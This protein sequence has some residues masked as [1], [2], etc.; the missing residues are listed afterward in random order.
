M[1]DHFSNHFREPFADRPRLDDVSLCFIYVKDNVN[2]TAHFLLTEIYG[3]ISLYDGTKIPGLDG[4]ILSFLRDFG[5]SSIMIMGVM[6]S[7]FR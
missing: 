1:V 5:P 7:Q 2:L 3:A 6:F 4:F